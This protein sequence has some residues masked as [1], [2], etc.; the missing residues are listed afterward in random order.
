MGAISSL[1]KKYPNVKIETA[2]KRYSKFYSNLIEFKESLIIVD[3]NLI[4][5]NMPEI[6]KKVSEKFNRKFD[7]GDNCEKFIG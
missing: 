5:K 6:I 2:L 4:T 7:I 3:F 1:I